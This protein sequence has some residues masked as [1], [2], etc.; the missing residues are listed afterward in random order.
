MCA[1]RED[2]GWKPEKS[3]RNWWADLGGVAGE[4]D[5][6]A[7]EKGHQAEGPAVRIFGKLDDVSEMDAVD[8]ARSPGRFFQWFALGKRRTFCEAG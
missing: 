6:S 2:S 8:L 5:F 4:P 1:L 3:G 7:A